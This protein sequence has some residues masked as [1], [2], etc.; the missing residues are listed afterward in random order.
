MTARSARHSQS[1]RGAGRRALRRRALRGAERSRAS[2]AALEREISSWPGYAPTPLVALPA[3][4]RSLGV[5][6]APLQGR[7][8]PLRPQELQGARRRLRGVP[9]AQKC[10][11]RAQRRRP[12]DRAAIAG[13]SDSATVTCATDGNHGRSVAWGARL[14]GCRCVI[15]VHETVSA[16]PR[17]T[18]SRSYGAEVIAR[19]GQL[20]RRGAPRGGRGAQATAGPSCPTRPTRATATFR[21]T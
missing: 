21:S 12:R 16:G 9:L 20:R 3:L 2:S 5:A 17:A 10:R 13:T 19:A 4:A 14:F 7:A 1:G 8:R 15:F 6:R 18:R 11:R